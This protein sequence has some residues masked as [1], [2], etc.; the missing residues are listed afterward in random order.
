VPVFYH[1][2]EKE[3][4]PQIHV[5]F[6]YIRRFGASG[7][8]YGRNEYCPAYPLRYDRRHPCSRRECSPREAG[9]PF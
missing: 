2:L 8:R 7:C 9:H 1:F 3:K 6:S 5:G 4:T